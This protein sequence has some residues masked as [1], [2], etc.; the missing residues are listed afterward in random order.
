MD[1]VGAARGPQAA[2]EPESDQSHSDGEL[3][4]PAPGERQVGGHSVKRLSGNWRV[5]AV[6]WVRESTVAQHC[7]SSPELLQQLGHDCS[8]RYDAIGDKIARML[9]SLMKLVPIGD[10]EGGHTDGH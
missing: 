3:A 4:Y 10:G 2:C 8:T 7:H 6:G 5:D 9:Q 1:S